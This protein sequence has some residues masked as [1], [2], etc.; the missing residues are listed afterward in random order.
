MALCLLCSAMPCVGSSAA[1]QEFPLYPVISKNVQFWEKIYAV[2]SLEQAVIH[3]SEDLSKIY[4]IVS[5]VDL[6]TPGAQQQ[7]S[8][9]QKQ[10]CE[11]YR[12][13]LTKLADQPPSTPEEQRVAALFPGKNAKQDM[14]LAANNV[15]SQ[16]GQKER[17]LSGVINS[18]AYLAEIKKIFRSYNL[19]E[20]LAH[21]PHVES[22]F[23]FKAYSRIGAAGLWQFTRETGKQYLAI[24][25]A[26][27]ERL[28]PIAS[29]HAAA[30]YLA[31]SFQNLNNWPLAIT[32][33]NYGLGGTIR[34]VNEEGSYERIFANYNKGYFKFASR[35]FYS[36]FLAARNVARYLEKN[37]NGRIAPEG[38]YQY[39]NLPGYAGI[40]EISRYFNLPVAMLADLNP[41]LR[42][43]VISG[44]KLIPKG[45]PLR[46][47]ASAKTSQ[48]VASLPPTLFRTDQKSSLYH[49]VRKGD[50][51]NSIARLHNIPVKTLIQ[52]NNLGQTAAIRLGQNLRIPGKLDAVINDNKR[53]S[54]SSR[55][56]IQKNVTTQETFLP[57]PHKGNS[58]QPFLERN[59][60][61]Q[62]K[63]LAKN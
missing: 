4:Q 10:A 47:L 43:P 31:K 54:S 9:I 59:K 36:E 2:Y 14:A 3:D 51:V 57:T 62:E 46:L 32:S 20:E 33:Y 55:I 60:S 13:I 37:L 34:A 26:V 44:E 42:P 50:T 25:Y 63:F 39:L 22:S 53:E 11:K 56:T 45:Y 41:A 19:P 17:F 8:A 23:N 49:L 24:D 18:G 27:D 28:D 21:L 40:Q 16:S 7:N 29:T 38:K 1:N 35:N 5:L 30:K 6:D 48:L 52:A 15:R 61:L 58:S 12:L